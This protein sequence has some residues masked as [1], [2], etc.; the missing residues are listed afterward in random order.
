MSCCQG[1]IPLEFKDRQF[2]LKCVKAQQLTRYLG[3]KYCIGA[4][5]KSGDKLKQTLNTRYI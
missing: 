2:S 4:G 3:L 5:R 1:E